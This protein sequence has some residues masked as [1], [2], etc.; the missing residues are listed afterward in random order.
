MALHPDFPKSPYEILDPQVRWF[1]GDKALQ[2]QGYIKLLAPLVYKLRQE[3][4]S[5][6]TR[7]YE[8][9]SETSKALLRWWFQTEHQTIDAN[10]NTYNFQYYFAQREAVE[11]VIYLYD[12]VKARNP[13]DL[14]RYDSS[15]SVSRGM[16]DEDWLRLVIKMATGS[17]KTKVISLLLAWSY[18]HKSYETDSEL[19]RNFLIITPNIIVLDRIRTDFDGLRIF[20]EDPIIPENGYEG[21]NWQD[22][23]QL[24]L[25]IQDEVKVIHKTGNI[26]LTN[27]HRVY[28]NEENIPS[29]DDEDTTDYFLGIKPTGKTNESKID[30]GE[31]VRNIDELMILNDEAHHIHDDKLAWFQSIQDIHN[32][33]LMKGKKLSLQL[34]VTATPKHTNGAIFVQT[35]TDYPLVEAI[36]QNVVKHPVAPDLA[37]RTK[38]QEHQSSKFTERYQD[39]LR[40]GYEEWK[41]TYNEHIKMNKKAVFFVMTD[42]TIN[43]DEVAEYLKN[44]FPEFADQ[45]SVLTIHTKRNGD[46]AEDQSGK[47]SEE[48]AHLRKISNEIDN[49]ESPYKAIVS[50][51]MLKEGWDVRNVTT[52]VGL[53]AYSSKSNILPEQTLG[54]GLRKMYRGHTVQE[55]VSIVG[56]DAFMDFVQSITREGVEL[57]YRRMGEGSEPKAPLIIEVENDNPQKDIEKLDIE[58]PILTPRIYREFKNLSELKPTEF[59]NKKIQLK[60]F[61][62]SEKREIVFREVIDGSHSHTTELDIHLKPSSTNVI[63]YFARN[64]MKEL[65]LVSGYDVLYE[66]LK[67]F[68]CNYLFETVVNIDD[69]NVLRNLSESE[70]YLTINNTFRQ[71][72]NE[73]TVKDKGNAEI[74]N[75]IKV[76]KAKPFIENDQGF[77]VSK[78]SIFNKI[79]GDSHFELEIASFLEDCNDIISYT[80]NYFSINFKIDYCNSQGGISNYY[81]DFVIKASPEEIYIIETKGREDLNDI[82]KLKRLKTWCQD[83]NQAQAKVKFQQLYIKQEDW[84]KLE[85]RPKSFRDLI[86]TFED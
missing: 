11:T 55:S 30:L 59:G 54:R 18:F 43:C 45:D 67:E 26:F 65:R 33:L 75:Y 70:V 47:G 60:E 17:G 72:I 84:D 10:N 58:I 51:L 85:I 44:N 35:I 31:I 56:T 12:V 76:S 16:F 64:I 19:A 15:Q 3:V 9:A 36:Y 46:I 49:L 8:G 20:N 62:E 27:I 74:Q 77:L 22:D 21:H 53:R 48:L 57:E 6:R 81:P 34:D 61:S 73:L 23:F 41:K 1:P 7:Y 63:G 25:H 38:L 29:F 78:K 4:K 28:Q 5:W 37:S 71:K 82:E 39:Y 32:K 68:I 50:V 40:L 79:I 83:V 24:N 14:M 86:K 42:D 52:I 69:D 13:Y 80:K 2:E 66:K